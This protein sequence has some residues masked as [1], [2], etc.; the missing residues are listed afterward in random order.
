M[1]FYE[2]PI[3][4]AIRIPLL[5][6]EWIFIVLTIELSLI[7]AMRFREREKGIRNYRELGY[8]SLMVGLG[9]MWIFYILGDYYASDVIKSPFLIWSEGSMRDLYLNLGY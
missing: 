7:F 4:G 1:I 6:L 3:T 8:F 5:I 2:F 9:L